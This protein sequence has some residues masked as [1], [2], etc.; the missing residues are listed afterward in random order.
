MTAPIPSACTA[1]RPPQDDAEPPRRRVIRIAAG[2]ATAAIG[3]LHGHAALADDPAEARPQVGDLL[4]LA[5]DEDAGKPLTAAG[6]AGNC[7]PL[8][9]FPVD[10][11]TGTVRNGSRFNKIALVRVDPASIES[12]PALRAAGGVLAFSAVCTHQGCDVT[13]W[14]EKAGTLL[15]FCH[16][17]QF[18]PRL[19]GQVAAGPAAKSLPWL[20]LRIDNGRLVIAG[21]FSAKPGP[22]KPG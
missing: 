17:S 22:S 6:I 4:V 18:D 11:A 9:A 19:E 1:C 14:N 5:T 7:K 3:G 16:F 8:H 21:G 2:F 12:E 13:E 20:P 15:C 10:P